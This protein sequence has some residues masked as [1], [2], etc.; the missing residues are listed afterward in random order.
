MGNEINTLHEFFVHTE[1]LAY[2]IIG[3]FL[4][5]FLCFYRVLVGR[6][7]EEE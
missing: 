6:E 4:I 2:I 5:S 3:V 7:T 1:G